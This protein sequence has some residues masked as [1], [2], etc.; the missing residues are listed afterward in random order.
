MSSR[1]AP[2]VAALTRGLVT[3]RLP[4]GCAAETPRVLLTF[5][6]GPSAEVTPGV[7]ERLAAHRARALFFAIG[8]RAVG[9]E[10]VLRSVLAGG[11][12]LG[13]HSHTHPTGRLPGW[14]AY[15]Q[16]VRT[17]GEAL[18]AAS[19]A[20]VRFFRAPEGR[21]HPASVWGVRGLGLRHVLWSLDS[22]DWMCEDATAARAAARGVLAE[23]RDG[24]IILLHE[25]A[26]WTWDLLDEL[27]PGLVGRGF[28]L[29]RGLGEL[30]GAG[31]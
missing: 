14:G 19:G 21:L 16:D 15:L 18:A 1:P 23:V 11:H 2:W 4:D 7:L 29:G 28:E 24:D 5:D 31:D 10:T 6:D 13:N 22:E 27:L 9:Q 25:Y 26:R 12:A 8:N 3:R 30:T 17:A 20:P